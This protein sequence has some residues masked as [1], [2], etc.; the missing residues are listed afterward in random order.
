MANNKT[1]IK[2]LVGISLVAVSVW[3]FTKPKTK[4]QMI[5]YLVKNKFHSNENELATFDDAFIKAWYDAAKLKLDK[6]PYNGT[7]HWVQGGTVAYI[8]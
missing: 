5:S 8:R 6:F 1:A 3:Y 4:A 7:N 2:V